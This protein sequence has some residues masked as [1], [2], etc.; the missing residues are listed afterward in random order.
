MIRAS[1]QSALVGNSREAYETTQWRWTE[2]KPRA[3]KNFLESILFSFQPLLITAGTGYKL[4]AMSLWLC[5]FT[6][7][8]DQRKSQG[9]VSAVERA[10]AYE[11]HDRRICLPVSTPIWQTTSISTIHYLYIITCIWVT[12]MTYLL[13]KKNQEMFLDYWKPR[14]RIASP[15]YMKSPNTVIL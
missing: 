12:A 6:I 13:Y 7:D 10:A 9:E 4:V 8:E 3:V 5:V 1:H 11:P 14:F 2:C 15:S